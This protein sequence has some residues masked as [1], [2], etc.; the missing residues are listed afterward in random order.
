[1]KLTGDNYWITL[2]ICYC[3]NKLE[4]LAKEKLNKKSIK[5]L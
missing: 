1:M 2:S 3:S 4:D 5:D